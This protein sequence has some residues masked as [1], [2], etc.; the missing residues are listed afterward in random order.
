MAKYTNQKAKILF[1]QEMMC[2]TGE[3]RTLSM[4]QILDKLQEKGIRAE[5]KSIY[6]DMDVLRYFGMDIAYSRERPSGYYLAGNIPSERR[7]EPVAEIP[8]ANVS[9]ET[10]GEKPNPEYWVQFLPGADDK[11]PMKLVCNGE[12]LKEAVQYFG[13]ACHYKKKEEDMYVVT[14]PMLETEGF[15]GWL[16]AMNQKVRIQK[17]KKT[18]QL[19][20]DYLKNI[21]KSYKI[22]K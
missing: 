5:R 10:E 19:Y 17:P 11:K 6:D 8:A 1:L 16:T 22:E 20:R 15:F 7:E 3:G 2:E 13:D 12:G 21:A 14:A 9:P 4:Q 18:A